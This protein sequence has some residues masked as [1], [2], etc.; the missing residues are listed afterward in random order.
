MSKPI[1]E[2]GRILQIAFIVSDVEAAAA[3]YAKLFG[4]DTPPVSV[5]GA[6]EDAHTEYWG[7]PSKARCKMA[8]IDLDNIQLEFIEPDEEE[9]DWKKSL[10]E[11]GDCLHHI[12]FE[13][14]GMK[15][16]IASLK[17][18]GIE[19]IQKGDYPGGR[20]AFMDTEKEYMVKFE[21]L[22]ND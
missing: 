19:C 14:K 8:F 9:S 10:E 1:L 6:Y 12:A 2:T 3:K 16:Q 20:Y 11:K 15:D 18:T 7:K 5:S 22:E 17:E 4:I 13:V 21:L